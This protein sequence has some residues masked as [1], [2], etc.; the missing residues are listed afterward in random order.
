MPFMV[1]A[2]AALVAGGVAARDQT[3][4]AGTD[5]VQVPVV[6]VG[7]SGEPVRGLT[8]DDFEVLENGRP[9]PLQFFAEG[10]AGEAL[11]L[12]LGLLLD[13]SESMQQDLSAAMTASIQ[14]VNAVEESVD[15]TLVDFDSVVRISRFEPGSYPQLFERIRSRKASG[16]TALY[17]ATGAYVEEASFRGGQHVLIMYTDGGDSSSSIGMGQLLEL[18]KFGSNV[19]VYPIGYLAHQRSSGR[20]EQQMRLGQIARESGGAA[21]FPGHVREM[22]QIYDT[23]LRELTS[24]YTVGYLPAARAGDDRFRKLEVRITRPDLKDAKVRTRPGYYAP[25]R[26]Q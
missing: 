9:Q 26:R 16:M 13:T 12:H 18:L 25:L 23:I 3:F 15:V 24:R 8:R 2:T 14:F 22:R 17:D 5:V 20:I 6:V 21:F 11:P 1:M 10:A 4:R 19:I 7:K